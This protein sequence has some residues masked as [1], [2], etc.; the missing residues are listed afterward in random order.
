MI[1]QRVNRPGTRFLGNPGSGIQK[2]VAPGK[3]YGGNSPFGRE[4]QGGNFSAVQHG[5]PCGSTSL[6]SFDAWVGSESLAVS[7][8]ELRFR[9]SK[10]PQRGHVDFLLLALYKKPSY[11]GWKSISHHLETMVEAIVCWY[12]QGNHHSRVC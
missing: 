12:L 9:I 11:G 6:G 7:T 10:W 2:T 3:R 8:Q 4:F 1:G 5:W